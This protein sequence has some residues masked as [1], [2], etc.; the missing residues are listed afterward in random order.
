MHIIFISVTFRKEST[1]ATTSI[2]V[3][4]AEAS[5]EREV[6]NRQEINYVPSYDPKV[7]LHSADQWKKMT[8]IRTYNNTRV[9]IE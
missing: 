7:D 6:E 8:N 3:F 1:Q 2:S 9:E 4:D 5:H